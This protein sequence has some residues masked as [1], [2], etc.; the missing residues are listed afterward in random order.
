MDLP[1]VTDDSSFADDVD[2]D[3]SREAELGFDV[4]GNGAGEGGGLDVV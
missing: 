2:F 3:F 4:G 1:C